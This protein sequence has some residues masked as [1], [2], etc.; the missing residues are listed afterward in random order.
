MTAEPGLQLAGPDVAAELARIQRAAQMREV[1]EAALRL[2]E[3][4]V[5]L[6]R[7]LHEAA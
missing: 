7:D 5:E 4:S 1:A 3:A 6:L 2:V